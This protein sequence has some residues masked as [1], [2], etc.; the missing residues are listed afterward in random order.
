M[1]AGQ[2]LSVWKEPRT[3]LIGLIV[4]GLAFAEGSANDWLPLAFVDGHGVDRATGALVFGIFVTAMTVGRVAG[5]TL[6]DAYGRVRVLRVSAA[7][8]AIGLI[9]VI[10]GPGAV[11][12][13]VGVV[14]WGLGTSLGFPVGLSAAGDDP[15]RAAAR[16]SAVATLGYLA[17]LAGPPI[18]GLLGQQTGLLHALLVVLV[19]VAI[20]GIVSPAARAISGAGTPRTLV[21][22]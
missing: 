17:F 10:F 8:A 16:V 18:L 5:S 9:I 19:L 13:A 15:R 3:L 4:L 14:F 21:R 20:S 22:R 2:R 6:L 12:A 7:A 11:V 1:T